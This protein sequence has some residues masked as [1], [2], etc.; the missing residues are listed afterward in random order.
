MNLEPAK[1]HPCYGCKYSCMGSGWAIYCEYIFI[2]GH[3]RP[4]PGGKDCTV[5]DTKSRRKELTIGNKTMCVADWAKRTGISKDTIYYWY[6]KLGRELTEKKVLEVWEG[7][8]ND[9]REI[10]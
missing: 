3:R 10:R 8:N 5:K 6:A 2:E 7:R 4:C 9:Q 1:K